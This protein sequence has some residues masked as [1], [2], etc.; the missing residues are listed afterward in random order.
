M[1]DRRQRR[2]RDRHHR[3]QRS[4]A[5]S[6]PYARLRS[7][8][9][10]HGCQSGRVVR[11]FAAHGCQVGR[12]HARPVRVSGPR[13]P[14]GPVVR[15]S[16]PRLRPTGQ[17][18][19]RGTRASPAFAAHGCQA[20]HPCAYPSRA[21]GPRV[22]SSSRYGCAG[23]AFAA[24]GCQTSRSH[25]HPDPVCGSEVTD[26]PA[27]YASRPRLRPRIHKRG[28]HA[29]AERNDQDHQSGDPLEQDHQL[30]IS[31]MPTAAEL[32][33]RRPSARPHERARAGAGPSPAVARGRALLGMSRNYQRVNRTSVGDGSAVQ[34]E[35]AAVGP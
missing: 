33:L 6:W 14:D 13:V 25:T 8:F 3:A 2:R 30:K 34:L 31:I 11:A 26:G 32:H 16:R 7:S 20:G 15:G 12:P 5:A 22:T 27:A 17:Q 35:H 29:P 4:Y 1:L 10:A 18:R 21:C 19:A 23:P 28:P 24:H 9:A